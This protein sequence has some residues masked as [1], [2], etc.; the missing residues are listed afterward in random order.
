MREIKFRGLEVLTGGWVFG[1]HVLTGTGSHYI[2]PQNLIASAI[3]QYHVDGNTVGQYTGLKDKNGKKI[4]TE[5]ITE[6]ELANGEIRRFVVRIKTVV[7][8]VVSHSS[9]S[10]DTAMVAITGVVFEWN[11]FELFPCVNEKGWH[12]NEYL[13]RVIGNIHENPELVEDSDGGL[14]KCYESGTL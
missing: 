12:D 11:G 6:I 1:S 3:P 10:D 5:D 9:F 4:Y 13:M 14:L 7:R 2:L 8:E